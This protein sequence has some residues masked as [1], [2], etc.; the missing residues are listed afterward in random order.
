[1]NN[2]VLFDLDGTL[3]DPKIGITRCIAHALERL[4]RPIVPPDELTWCIGP[5][6]VASFPTLLGSEDPVLVDQAIALY[7]ERFTEIG[8]FENAVYEGVPEMLDTLRASGYQ[9]FVATSKPLPY[10]IRILDHFALADAFENV[11]GSGLDG[12]L[13]DKG[14]LLIH[15]LMDADLVPE[16]TFMVGDRKHDVLGARRAGLECLGVLYGYGSQ[17]ELTEAGAAVLCAT[18]DFVA[19]EIIFRRSSRFPE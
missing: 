8:L 7:R 18:P 11:Y 12:S 17:S 13:S 5:P 15:A 16:T 2:A 3:T 9:L 14:D 19:D 10:A 1:M 6:L 4:G